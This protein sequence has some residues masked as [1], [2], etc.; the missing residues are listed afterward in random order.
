MQRTLSTSSPETVPNA[1]SPREA[2][3]SVGGELRPISGH[4]GLL[5]EMVGHMENEA[6]NGAREGSFRMD[7]R[8]RL[9]YDLLGK[10]HITILGYD[11]LSFEADESTIAR[12][13]FQLVRSSDLAYDAVVAADDIVA[14]IESGARR[15]L[16]ALHGS[17]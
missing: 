10:P 16:L 6:H 1:E 3:V 8:V 17:P 4:A 2:T 13:A 15:T 11:I 14:Q 7:A 5:A 12:E 9:E